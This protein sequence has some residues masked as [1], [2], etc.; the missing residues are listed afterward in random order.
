MACA[1]PFD[2]NDLFD[3][4]R[5]ALPYASLDRRTFDRTIDFVATGGYALKAYDRFAKLKPTDDG[6]LRIAHPRVAQQYRLNAGTIVDSP[7]LK[8]RLVSERRR[9]LA[10]SGNVQGG[11]VLGEVEEDFID[12]LAPGDTFV[13]AGEVLRFAGLRRDRGLRHAGAIPRSDDPELC[14]RQVSAFNPSCS[15]RCAPCSRTRKPGEAA[16][17]RRRMAEAAEKVLRPS[18]PRRRADRNLSAR[19]ERFYLV[20]YP[21]E[22]RLAHQTLGM[23]LTRRLDRAG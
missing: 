16:E 1:A 4:V 8:I 12:Q 18:R 23:L 11:R 3:E 15:A 14:R 19:G 17:A 20:A 2:A 13:F 21:F 9:Q 5:S 6:K 22:G 7:M 10:K